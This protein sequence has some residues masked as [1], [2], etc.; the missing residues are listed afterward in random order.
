MVYWPKGLILTYQGKRRIDG[1]EYDYFYSDSGKQI[2]DLDDMAN[3]ENFEIS[4]EN[5]DEK[6]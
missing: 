3:N 5:I 2:L 4:I 6:R 1:E